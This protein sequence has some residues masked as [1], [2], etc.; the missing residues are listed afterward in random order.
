MTVLR[1][2][3]QRMLV[4]WLVGWF[5]HGCVVVRQEFSAAALTPTLLSDLMKC[6][7]FGEFKGGARW[8]VGCWLV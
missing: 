6:I 4:G 5:D 7:S 1:A 8:C 2:W 3:M